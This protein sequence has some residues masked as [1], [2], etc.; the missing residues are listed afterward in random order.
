MDSTKKDISDLSDIELVEI[1][2]ESE[3]E[4]T[5]LRNNLNIISAELIKRVEANKKSKQKK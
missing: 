4:I 1:Q 5:R 2:I 3:R